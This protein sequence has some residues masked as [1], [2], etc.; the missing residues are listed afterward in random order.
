MIMNAQTPTPS[1]AVAGRRALLMIAAVGLLV[2]TGGHAATPAKPPA[3][4][5]A[6]KPAAAKRAPARPAAA[7]AAGGTPSYTAAQATR[8][9]ALFSTNCEVCHGAGGDG[10]EFGPQLKGAPHA[11]YWAGKT[12]K[13]MF[14]FID[15][16]MPPTQP[17]LL[18]PQGTADVVAY[19]LRINGAPAGTTEVAANSA[20]L[21]A[22]KAVK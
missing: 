3:K 22:F 10:G 18:G 13:D 6:T 5:A 9:A 4:A 20:T 1:M 8:G 17:G 2:A 12:A 19:L 15:T 16:S 21:G 14:E 7:G 11:A